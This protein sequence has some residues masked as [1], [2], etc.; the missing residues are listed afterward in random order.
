MTKSYNTDRYPEADY[1]PNDM[2]PPQSS[3]GP[4]KWKEF[5]DLEKKGWEQEK[6]QDAI[7]DLIF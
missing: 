5:E 3:N 1:T 6:T 7:N 2:G 4:E